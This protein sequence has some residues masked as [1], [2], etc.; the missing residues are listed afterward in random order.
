M[1]AQLT[2]KIPSESR[3]RFARSSIA[4]YQN[5]TREELIAELLARDSENMKLQQEIL[6]LKKGY[7]YIVQFDGDE[8]K[9]IYKAGKTGSNIEN[10]FANYR[11]AFGDKLGDLNIVRVAAV[12]DSLAAEQM[13]HEQ[14]RNSGVV[15]CNERAWLAGTECLSERNKKSLTK[16]E[17]YIDHGME[18]V[19]KAFDQVVGKYGIDED[20]IVRK[21]DRYAKNDLEDRLVPIT[22]YKEFELEENRYYF[23]SETKKVYKRTTHGLDVMTP[24]PSTKKFGMNKKVAGSSLL[25]LDYIIREYSK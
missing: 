1:A 19:E 5:M 2:Q 4:D 15:S 22:H 25:S 8:E 23:D 16:S 17:W 7:I 20:D 21:Y 9:G 3:E 14:I 24:Q 12:S 10:R 11:S 18:N 13:M 6:E